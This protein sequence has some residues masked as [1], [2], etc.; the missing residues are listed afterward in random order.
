MM[1]TILLNHLF[2][3]ND[4]YHSHIL[5]LAS[6]PLYRILQLIIG[7]IQYSSIRTNYITLKFR[8]NFA[9]GKIISIFS[10]KQFMGFSY[11]TGV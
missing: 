5:N 6:I 7:N 1:A 8:G 9:G 11:Y 3:N 4:M 10:G 2:S